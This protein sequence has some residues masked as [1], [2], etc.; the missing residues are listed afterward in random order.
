MV[1]SKKYE[2]FKKFV[3]KDKP[4]SKDKISIPIFILS[5]RMDSVLEEVKENQM[6]FLLNYVQLE[7][8]K[9]EQNY[10]LAEHTGKKDFEKEF[11]KF[12][13]EFFYDLKKKLKKI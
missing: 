5:Q 3:L 8:E 13:K 9:A 1:D 7:Y 11:E 4:K 12:K 6:Q 10:I 2:D